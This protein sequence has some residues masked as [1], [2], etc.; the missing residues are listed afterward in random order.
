MA[1]ARKGARIKPRG[2]RGGSRA[3]KIVKWLFLLLFL[4]VFAGGLSLGALFFYYAHELPDITSLKGYAP[5]RVTRVY[6]LNGELIGELLYEGTS[7][8]KERRTPVALEDIPPKLIDAFLCAEDADFFKHAGIDYFGI[9]RALYK[10]AIKG[11]FTQGASTITQQVVKTF[12][13]SPERTF[14]RKFQELILA[15]RLE[16]YLT[17]EEILALYLNQIY[18]GN[19]RFGIVEAAR[20][21]FNKDLKSLSLSEMAILAGMPKAPSELNPREASKGEAQRKRLEDRRRFVLNQMLQ[22]G[23]ISQ[24]EME[25][26]DKAPIE[27][28]KPEEPYLGIAPGFLEEVKAQLEARFD[29]S[30]LPLLGARVETT[31]DPKMQLAA[32]KALRAALEKLDTEQGY[33]DP[34]LERPKKPQKFLE[35]ASALLE[36]PKT[37]KLVGMQYGK[38]Y[39]GLIVAVSDTLG[40]YVINVGGE[41]GWAYLKENARYNSKGAVPSKFASVGDAIPVSVK[42]PLSGDAPRTLAA[43]KERDKNAL[44]IDSIPLQEDA[45]I[46]KELSFSLGP[47]GAMVAIDPVTFEIRAMVGGYKET[48]GGL[49]RATRAKRQPG[50]TFKPIVYSAALSL[51]CATIEMP[52]TALKEERCYSPATLLRDQ[53]IVSD[54]GKW[55]PNNADKKELGDISMRKS[56]AQ[57]RN[58]STINLAREITIERVVEYAKT[59]GYESEIQPVLPSAL[60]ASEVTP[61]EQAQVY[62]VFAS[63]GMRKKP[64]Y[65]RKIVLPDGQEILPEEEEPVRVIPEDVAYLTTSLLQ[66]VIREGTGSKAQALGRPAGGKTGTTNDYTD[67]WFVGYTP[68]LVASLWLGFDDPRRSLQNPK[69]PKGKKKSVSGGGNAAPFWTQFMKEA[70]QGKGNST[71]KE[72]PGIVHVSI[73]PKSGLRAYDGQPDA[74]EEI[75]SID[76][77]PR[78]EAPR[79]DEATIDDYILSNSMASPS[80]EDLET[81][82]END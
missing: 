18:F 66:S 70:L 20:Y 39:P 74:I 31:L 57:S 35:D 32:E 23:K 62:A 38:T 63:G 29:A 17:K 56:L 40:G 45:P 4:G 77:V 47:E 71:F 58:L 34:K 60:G 16:Q 27:W 55:I 15:K 6:G 59:L 9:A 73:D 44:L 72:P 80:P 76:T 65:I 14:K 3:L 64:G 68:D 7:G 42:A 26:A 33:R 48:P 69:P 2:G 19:H 28:N 54:D 5:V 79:P 51:K 82:S 25:A 67:A 37:G 46:K 78:E 53:I 52:G 13:L 49:N 75:F 36:D 12:L 30:Q 8:Q 22:K 11:E 10:A 61:L 21:Y 50:S 81:L 1:L 41:L 24:A 43:L